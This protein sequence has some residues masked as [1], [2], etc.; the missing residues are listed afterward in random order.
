MNWMEY[1]QLELIPDILWHH[2]TNC[3]KETSTICIYKIVH[4][5]S[6]NGPGADE[7]GGG[8]G[9]SVVGFAFFLENMETFLSRRFEKIFVLLSSDDLF[10]SFG[11]DFFSSF[12][13]RFH[14][15]WRSL[16]IKLSL[17]LNRFLLSRGDFSSGASIIWRVSSGWVTMA[18]IVS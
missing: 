4:S 12:G 17:I 7:G 11:D 3:T 1:L 6:S 16:P 5:L 8:G 15:G 13:A 10:S 2:S 18:S 9:T 14:S